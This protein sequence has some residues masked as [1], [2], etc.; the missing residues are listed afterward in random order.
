MTE[1]NAL[2][3]RARGEVVRVEG[4]TAIVGRSRG[5]EVRVDEGGVSRRHCEVML[6]DDGVYVRD[7]GSSHGTWTRGRRVLAEARL[8]AGDVVSLGAHGP[9]LEVVDAVLRGRRVHFGP[10]DD[11]AAAAEP[12]VAERS[13]VATAFSRGR[14]L[15]GLACGA[16]VGA[17]CGVAVLALWR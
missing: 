9:R 8:G 15:A 1:E 5:C 2:F 4:R 3:I 11:A 6:R 13:P 16:A 7:L 17:A 12:T 10:Q 14:F